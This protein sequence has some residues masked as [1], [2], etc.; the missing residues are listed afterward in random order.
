VVGLGGAG[1][2]WLQL[3]DGTGADL[4]WTR[5]AVPEFQGAQKATYPAVGRVR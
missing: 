2:G 1:A 5:V 4:G 3:F